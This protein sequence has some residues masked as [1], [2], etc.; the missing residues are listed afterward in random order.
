MMGWATRR[1]QVG[2]HI[3]VLAGARCPYILREVGDGYELVGAAYVHG[4]MEAPE[5]G[6]DPRAASIALVDPP[7]DIWLI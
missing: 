7:K 1:A 4:L 2:D 3:A 6:Y 5:N